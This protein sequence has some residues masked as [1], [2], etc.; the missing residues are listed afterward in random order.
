MVTC[1]RSAG[2]KE[3]EHEHGTCRTEVDRPYSNT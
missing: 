2:S 3:G 1:G